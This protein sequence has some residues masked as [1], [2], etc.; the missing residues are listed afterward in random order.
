MSDTVQV[1]KNK[2]LIGDDIYDVAKLPPIR[3]DFIAKLENALM[4]MNYRS[5]NSWTSEAHSNVN[6]KNFDGA[7]LVEVSLKH[8]E[9]EEFAFTPFTDL[10]VTPDMFPSMN[11]KCMNLTGDVGSIFKTRFLDRKERRHLEGYRYIIS[12]RSAI[13]DYGNQKWVT[14]EQGFGFNNVTSMGDIKI[15]IPIPTSLKA[16]YQIDQIEAKRHIA[17]GIKDS[18]SWYWHTIK[19][20]HM[21][22]Q[23]SLTYYYE[24]SCYIKETPDSIGI[25]IPIHPSSSKEVF[26]LRNTPEGGGRRKAIVN[27]VKDHYRTIKGYNNN[28]REVLIKKHFR[29]ELKFR[30]RGLEVHITPSAYD[31]KRIKTKK[32]FNK[33]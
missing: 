3:N 13:L 30:W 33:T 23:L 11:I 7:W 20:I 26:M 1:F 17:E 10:Q 24:W 2:E 22:L 5:L 12:Q 18:E 31:L 16:G 15:I 25:R 27:F 28:E 6:L 8:S 29:G 4:F 19:S 9:D 14:D 32:K 21:S